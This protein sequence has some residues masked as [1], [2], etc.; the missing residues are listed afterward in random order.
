MRVCVWF[1]LSLL[2]DIYVIF[3]H[4]CYTKYC[5]L[6]AGAFTLGNLP[7]RYFTACTCCTCDGKDVTGEREQATALVHG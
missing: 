5:L 7:G 6:A 2:F 4:F 3:V 1:G